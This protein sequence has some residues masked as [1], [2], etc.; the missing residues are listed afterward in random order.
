MARTLPYPELAVK[1]PTSNLVS[2]KVLTSMLSQ[3]IICSFAQGFA[4]WY[5]TI[6]PWYQEPTVDPDELNVVN[7]INSTLFLV[8]IFQYI[9]V[10]AVFSVGPPY[11]KPMWSNAWL[12]A[13][14]VVLGSACTYFLFCEPGSFAFDILGLV[15]MPHSFHWA[16]AAIVVA[17]VVL[18]FAAE[19]YMI[20][21]V[22]K[23]IK[24]SQRFWRKRRR[25]RSAAAAGGGGHHYK[26]V[27][28]QLRE[29]GTA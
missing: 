29:E 8:S 11:R 27:Q 1:R 16:L 4:Y 9:L 3:V 15:D 24:A 22:T 25:T 7:P 21:P 19:A 12:M 13:C 2:K 5:T 20:K 23:A 28:Q 14:L 26:V 17:N 10:A 6:Q 18:S